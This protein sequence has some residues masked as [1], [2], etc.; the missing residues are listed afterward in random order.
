MLKQQSTR[1]Q[2]PE[3]TQG[4]V[5]GDLVTPQM[6][7][8]STSGNGYS[9]PKDSLAL[10]RHK[11]DQYLHADPR[12]QDTPTSSG[13]DDFHNAEPKKRISQFG[14]SK[15]G[16]QIREKKNGDQALSNIVEE[17]NISNLSSVQTSEMPTEQNLISEKFEGE[18]AENLSK[19]EGDNIGE[20]S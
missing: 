3:T 2:V 12:Q 7:K 4:V 1:G 16:I 20:T 11:S 19:L 15:T 6:Q 9:S 13:D 5:S 8:N 17:E 18:G 14:R 10:A